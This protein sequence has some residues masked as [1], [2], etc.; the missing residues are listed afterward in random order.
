MVGLETQAS[1][2]RAQVGV[3]AQ[4][5]TETEVRAQVRGTRRSRC[6]TEQRSMNVSN[7]SYIRLI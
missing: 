3:D 1:Q 6:A 2:G 5:K 4:G 7:I